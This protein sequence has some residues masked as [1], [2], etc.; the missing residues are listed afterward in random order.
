MSF[1]YFV[2]FGAVVALIVATMLG[3][4]RANDGHLEVALPSPSTGYLALMTMASTPSHHV[5]P[6]LGRFGIG[7][8]TIFF[9]RGLPFISG[10]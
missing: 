9:P 7:L 10:P 8:H 2:V 5:R 6:P 3:A 4:R 1:G